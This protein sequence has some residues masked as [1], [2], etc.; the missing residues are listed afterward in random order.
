[1]VDLNRGSGDRSERHS[2]GS[3]LVAAAYGG[4]PGSTG[5]RDIGPSADD[6][7]IRFNHITGKVSGSQEVRPEVKCI[8]R[9]A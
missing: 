6:G 2:V 8:V 1:M 4:F 3:S 9:L 7:E 5:G